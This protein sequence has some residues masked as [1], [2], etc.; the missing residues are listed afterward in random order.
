MEKRPNSDAE[1]C[2]YQ[3]AWM[4]DNP[5]R[6]LLH[7]PRKILAGILQSGQTAV[8]L[9]CGPGYFTME[10]ARLVGE[11][12]HVIAADMQKEM[13]AMVTRRALKEGVS[14]RV[15]FH[16][17]G[18]ECIGIPPGTADFVLSFWMVHEVPNQKAFLGEVF[19]LLKPGGRYLLVEPILHV[20]KADFEKTVELAVSA[21]FTPEAQPKI[22]ISRSVLLKR[23]EK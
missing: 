5:L 10:M 21:G 16:Q 1:V 15:R 3:L 7:N 6:R 9:G 18:Q 13:L 4:L 19:T 20:N 14:S 2:S 8:D 11:N 23:A 12:G 22:S 17:C